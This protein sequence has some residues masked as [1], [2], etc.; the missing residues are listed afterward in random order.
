[1]NI[2]SSL[3]QRLGG[4]AVVNQL[5][6]L[7]IQHLQDDY[8][9]NRFFNEQPINNKARAL[10]ALLTALLTGTKGT[11]LE[12]VLDDFFMA[13]FAKNNKKR[14]LVSGAD[15]AVIAE[16]FGG[17]EVFDPVP[18]C[19][20]HTHLLKY[21]PEDFHYDVVIEHARTIAQ[22]LALPADVSQALLSLAEQGRSA[23]L[24]RG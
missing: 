18:V 24:G 16:T 5:A 2:D 6:N 14:S 11:A 12:T 17:L 1:M 4:D 19:E 23:I 9:I 13:V 21:H 22:Q 7:L 15:F 10:S 8:R 3:Y 20:A